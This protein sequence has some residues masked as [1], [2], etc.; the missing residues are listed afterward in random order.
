MKKQLQEFYLDWVNNYLTMEK[1]AEHYGLTSEAVETLIDL[2]RLYHEEGVETMRKPQ[3]N[4]PYEEF[5][6]YLSDIVDKRP[7]LTP[8]EA[9]KVLGLLEEDVKWCIDSYIDYHATDILNKRPQLE[10]DLTSHG[11]ANKC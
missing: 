8:D 10:L 5:R 2:G 11:V 1:M 4:E 6:C 7:D 3:I 9:E